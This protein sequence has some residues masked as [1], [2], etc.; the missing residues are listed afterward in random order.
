MEIASPAPEALVAK[1]LLVDDVPANLVALEAVLEPLGQTLIRAHSGEEAL[2]HL[3]QHDFAVILMDVQMPELDGLETVA[4]IKARERSRHVPVIFITALSREMAYI[5]KGYAGGAVDYLLKPV[6]ADIL[7]AKVSVFVDL[8][9]RGERLKSQAM[10]LS[11]RRRIEAEIAAAVEFQE[12][13]VGI[14]GHDIRSPLSALLATA[15]MLLAMGELTERQSKA[16][17]RI[18]RS[19]VRIES[20]VK[21]LLDFASARIG[22]GIK[23]VR[24]EMDLHSLPPK[25]VEEVQQSNPGRIIQCSYEG[26]GRG[27]WDADRLMQ[28]LVNL[29]DNALK[30]S[31]EGTPVDISTRGEP[32][33]VLLE[34]HNLGE[35]VPPALL[36]TLFEPFRRGAQSE[37]TVKMS[38]GLG[39]YIVQEIVRAHGGAVDVRSSA[40]SGTTFRVRLPRKAG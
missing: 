10:E 39:L 16:I 36:P 32:N 8:Y 22:G 9:L 21:V 18:A 31:P 26:D 11:E 37:Q 35:P 5:I 1:I 33:S 28:V 17:D 15:K 25:G 3:L 30:Y 4:L 23:V 38:L 13:L 19:G 2:K 40:D 20:I 29:L 27:E 34:V 14:I 6:D 7:R 12:R 24:R